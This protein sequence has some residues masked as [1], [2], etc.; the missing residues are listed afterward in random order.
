MCAAA[1][2]ILLATAGTAAPQK[3]YTYVGSVGTDHVLLAWGTAGGDNT[4]GRSS[5]PHGKVTVRIGNQ[6]VTVADR[7][8]T[9]VSGLEPDTAYDYEVLLNGSRIGR[10]RVRTWPQKSE[11]LRFFVIGDFGTGDS[12]QRRVAGAMWKE[13]ERLDGDN[14][15]R[16]VL[17]TGDNIYG[18]FTFTLRFKDTGNED[19]D[20]AEKYF[21][22]YESVIARVPFFATLGNHDGNETEARADLTTYLDNFFFPS[23]EP[24]RYY[25]FSYGG[26]VDFF[27]LDTTTNSSEG[28]PRPAYLRDSDQHKWLAK[29]LSESRTPWKIPYMHHPPYNAGP[30][31]PAVRN[32]LAHFLDLFR[33]NGVRVVFSGHEHNFQFST[34]NGETGG[35]RYVITGAG[36][37]LRGGNVQSEMREAQVEGWAAELHFLS[38]EIE[39]REMRITPVFARPAEVVDAA[40]R[41]MQMP[42]RVTLP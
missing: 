3:F 24:A 37:E 2:A 30:R 12:H 16:F 28:P 9:I 39:G 41:R 36:G 34:A 23:P 21:Q 6:T 7:N 8:W 25:R 1:I 32:E 18:Q 5:R 31:H 13:F 20:W 29:N 27:A 35:I 14:P 10:A 15:V 33:S 22:P 19:E 26:H 42:L 17:T 11:R 4:I 40:G 38:V